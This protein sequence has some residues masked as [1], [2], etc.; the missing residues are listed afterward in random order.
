MQI[1][2]TPEN[3]PI[4]SHQKTCEISEMQMH[5][6]SCGF[7][8]YTISYYSSQLTYLCKIILRIPTPLRI[9][10]RL[11]YVSLPPLRMYVRLYYVTLPPCDNVMYVMYVMYVVYVMYVMYVIVC[12][13][14]QKVS[15][16]HVVGHC[17]EL[18]EGFCI[19]RS[20]TVTHL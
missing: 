2:V 5:N 6:Y 16:K 13:V 14:C 17:W 18:L 11:Y 10:V 19:S 15:W 12:P 3:F 8:D 4:G 20:V 9:Y 7:Q 1:S